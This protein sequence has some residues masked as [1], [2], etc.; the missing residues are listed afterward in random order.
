MLARMPALVG[1]DLGGA[2]T[3]V[4]PGAADLGASNDIKARGRISKRLWRDQHLVRVRP[5]VAI[6]LPDVAYLANL[7]EVELGGDEFAAVTRAGRDEG[8]ARI[9]EVALPVKFADVPRRLGADAIDRAN[10]V[11]VGD[12]M[13]GL[14]E[15]PQIFGQAGDRGRRIEH[16]LRPAEAER[17]RAFRKMAVVADVYAD[18]AVLGLEHRITEIAGAE[19][20]FLPETRQAMRNMVLA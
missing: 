5:A 12:G 3:T 10:E 17:T 8:A 9:A 19:I 18:L 20:E 2:P 6:E 13:R 14:F 11:G 4:W 7:V 1:A 16:D 15:L